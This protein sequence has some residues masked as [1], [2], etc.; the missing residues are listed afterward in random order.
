MPL[1]ILNPYVSENVNV[2]GNKLI[3]K[4]NFIVAFGI[5]GWKIKM[6]TGT[7]SEYVIIKID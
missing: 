3:N 2:Y 1:N 4:T 6:K 7:F 5:S